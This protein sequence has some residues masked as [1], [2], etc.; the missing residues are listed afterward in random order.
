MTRTT[1]YF[2]RHL[3]YSKFTDNF[4]LYNLRVQHPPNLSTPYPELIRLIGAIFLRK[5]LD[6]RAVSTRA[7]AALHIQP[8]ILGKG[9]IPAAG[10]CLLTTNHYTRPGF[11][12]WWMVMLISSAIPAP[13]HWVI[14]EAWTMEGKWYGAAWTSITRWFFHRVAQVYGFKT[15]PP[16][17]PRRFEVERRAQAVRN[18]LAYARNRSDL[19]IGMSPEGQD[20]QKCVL[21]APPV[22]AGRFLYHFNRD[23]YPILPVGV[24][25]VGLAPCVSFGSLYNLYPPDGIS[26][27]DL[28]GWVS[29]KVMCSIAGLLPPNLRGEYAPC[30]G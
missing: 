29:N 7:C 10:P 3:F 22:G 26:P 13:V 9:N 16:M 21:Q 24:F 27:A 2:S 11:Q 20:E 15:M 18:V 30:E 5:S 12:S 1:L 14:S 4:I 19:I 17:P 25:E 28:D 6:F 8:I 23:G